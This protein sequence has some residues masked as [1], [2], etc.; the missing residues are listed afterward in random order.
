MKN[1]FDSVKNRYQNNSRSMRNNKLVIDYVKL[2][3][4]KCH[5]INLNCGVSYIDSVLILSGLD[6][7][8]KSKTKSYQ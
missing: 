4:Y 1:L 5:K 2:L 6:K 8:Q 7:K 3:Y